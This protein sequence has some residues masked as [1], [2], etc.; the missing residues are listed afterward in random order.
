MSREQAQVQNS[1]FSFLFLFLFRRRTGRS[2]RSGVVALA[3]AIGLIGATATPAA[4]A[5]RARAAACAPGGNVAFGL[6]EITTSGCLNQVGTSEWKTAD[7]VKLNG[8]PLTPAPGTELDVTQSGADGAGRLSVNAAISVSGVTFAKQGLLSLDLP[9]GRAGDEKRVFGTGQLSGDKMFGLPIS[10]SFEIRL[11]EDARN[12]RYAKFIGNV[13]LPS[14]FKNGPDQQAGGLTGAVG[15]RVDRD[16]IHADA[17]KIEVANAYIGALQVKNLCLSFASSGNTTTTPC[18]PPK[19]GA[20]PFLQCQN[21]GQVDRWDGS[22]EVVIP[23][24]DR[25]AVGVWAGVQNGQF[26][27]AG[28]QVTHLG[29][30]VPLAPQVYLD[31]VALA[32]CITPPPMVFKGTVGVNLGQTVNGVAPVS[33]SGTVQYTDSRPWVLRADGSLEVFGYHVADGFIQYRSDNTIDFGF[34]AALDFKIASVEAHLSGWIEARTPL[35]FNVDGSGKVCVFGIACTGGELT[36][37]SVGLAGCITVMEG[38]IWELVKDSNWEWWAFWRVHWELH[39]WRVRAG[40]GIKWGGDVRLMGDEC[41]VGPYRAARSARV[42]AA[43]DFTVKVPSGQ[44]ALVLKAQGVKKAPRI[45]LISP[46]GQTFTT[47]SDGGE[48]VK[49][50]DMIV[51]DP[52]THATQALI[53]KPAAGIWKIHPLKGSTIASIEQAHVDE[54]PTIQ[55]GVGGSG[56]HRI[57]G[58]SYQPQPDHTARFVEE[59]AKYEHELGR[60][61]GKPCKGVKKIHPD[62]GLCGQIHFTPA[63]GPAGVRHIYAVVTM[64][65]VETRRELVATYDAPPEPEPS[66]VPHLRVHRVPGALQISWDDSHAAIRAARPVDYDVDVNLTDG[67]KLLYVLRSNTDHVTVP[68]VASDVGARVMVSPVR[69]DDTVGR[70]QSLTIEVGAAQA[71]I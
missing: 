21:P 40:L 70:T 20:E 57:L 49:N 54:K 15:L 9:G 42:S 28:G 19:F 14:V 53:A 6:W 7:A 35:R 8:V 24:A 1:G 58:Y 67:R 22:A 47:P 36:A 65:G 44:T 30:S 64:N 18:S 17:V 5:P 23:T 56:E 13:Q 43:G 3:A 63:P 52:Q 61:E 27:Y 69:S 45:E 29:N 48:L 60:A 59:G 32:V 16:G 38:D 11:G 68:D 31:K 12:V 37:S 62:P 41:D 26:S 66:K 71:S 2:V 50:R 51:E 55:A 34:N 46:S 33:L 10:G 4:A 39:H 25:P